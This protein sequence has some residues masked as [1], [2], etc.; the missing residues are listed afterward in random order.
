MKSLPV[1][2]RYRSLL[3]RLYAL[4]LVGLLPLRLGFL[5]TGAFVRNLHL[6]QSLTVRNVGM[7]ADHPV[8]AVGVTS[9][10]NLG[11]GNF[12]SSVSPIPGVVSGMRLTTCVYVHVPDR[13]SSSQVKPCAYGPLRK[14]G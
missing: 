6:L 11:R 7:R 13:Q 12:I 3:S 14:A 8:A 1:K 10:R 4:F 2:K 9:K 5:E